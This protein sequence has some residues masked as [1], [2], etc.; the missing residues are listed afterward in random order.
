[1]AIVLTIRSWERITPAN[2]NLQSFAALDL[3]NQNVWQRQFNS[4]MPRELVKRIER[5][6]RSAH[7][8]SGGA[9]TLEELCRHIWRADKKRLLALARKVNLTY[10][11][12][13]FE[14]EDTE[15]LRRTSGDR[16]CR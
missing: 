6:E 13:Q 8:G 12:Q 15:A 9:L 2:R 16:G 1:L 4:K 11:I 7:G 10:F 3:Y 5:L 14:F